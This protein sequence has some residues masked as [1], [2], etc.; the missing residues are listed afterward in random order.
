MLHRSPRS[1]LRLIRPCRSRFHTPHHP[2]RRPTPR[3]CFSGSVCVW[4]LGDCRCPREFC[5]P[6]SRMVMS[7]NT[8]WGEK[9]KYSVVRS[10]SSVNHND[11]APIVIQTKMPSV[12]II[13]TK[14]AVTVGSTWEVLGGFCTV[15]F[16]TPVKPSPEST[17]RQQMKVFR[18]GQGAA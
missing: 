16:Q 8:V 3:A 4:L 14:A 6:S 9:E 2:S 18:Q 10:L 1:C 15:S 12:V 5:A 11:I 17:P 13:T 7:S